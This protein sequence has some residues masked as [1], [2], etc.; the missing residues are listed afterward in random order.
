MHTH[1]YIRNIYICKKEN[2][3]VYQNPELNE[4]S[5]D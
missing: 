3:D 4:A 5:K 2:L 1:S